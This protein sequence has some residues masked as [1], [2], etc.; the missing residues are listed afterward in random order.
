[1]WLPMS[2]PSQNG[3]LVC[4]G[5]DMEPVACGNRS[6]PHRSFSAY[7]RHA[8]AV[9]ATTLAFLCRKAHTR[10]EIGRRPPRWGTSWGTR[11]DGKRHFCS[12]ARSHPQRPVPLLASHHS[13]V[14]RRGH[15]R[16]KAGAASCAKVGRGL[17]RGLLP[18]RPPPSAPGL[19]TTSP[20]GASPAATHP[21]KLEHCRG[22]HCVA[23]RTWFVP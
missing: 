9:R 17:A 22:A 8:S 23:S 11:A 12:S 6:S 21:L 20:P 15:D 13:P 1:M 5:C 2:Y 7:W 14:P 3:M 19:T 10:H 16:Q 4:H 18:Q